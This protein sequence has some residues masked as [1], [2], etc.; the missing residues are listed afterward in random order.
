MERIFTDVSKGPHCAS[1]LPPRVGGFLAFALWTFN[2]PLPGPSSAPPF[3]DPPL[4][5]ALLHQA[6]ASLGAPAP[7][8]R[9]VGGELQTRAPGFRRTRSLSGRGGSG[10]VRRPPWWPSTQ[11]KPCLL[12]K[13]ESTGGRW[14][15]ARVQPDSTVPLGKGSHL[16]PG[17]PVPLKGWIWRPQDRDH[18]MGG[19]APIPLAAGIQELSGIC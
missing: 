1:L 17:G 19:R 13:A 3:P 14:T 12:R 11:R 9:G 7:W 15:T 4:A 16:A 18:L 10:E 8:L 2:V 6:K 5:V